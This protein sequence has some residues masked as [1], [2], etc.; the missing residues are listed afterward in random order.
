MSAPPVD[1]VFASARREALVVLVTWICALA[2]TVGYC[3]LYGYD[4][5]ADD[6]AFVWGF[7]DWVFWGILAPWGV[8][9]L[10]SYWFSYRFMTDEDLGAEVEE[11]RDGAFAGTG[12]QTHV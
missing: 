11:E 8:C 9:L 1:P 10:V 7:P 2:Y 3:D 4:R 5:S 12:G 6:L